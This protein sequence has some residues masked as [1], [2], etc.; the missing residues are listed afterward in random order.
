MQLLFPDEPDDG[1]LADAQQGSRIGHGQD[2]LRVGRWQ[3]R[4]YS[5]GILQSRYLV[6]WI[7]V[8]DLKGWVLRLGVLDSGLLGHIAMRS[9]SFGA[10]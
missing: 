6:E 4:T 3:A 9:A 5:S 7:V 2:D 10:V 1:G 8:G